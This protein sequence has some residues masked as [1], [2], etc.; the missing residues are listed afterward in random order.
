MKLLQI[1]R[2]EPDPDVVKLA[3]ILSDGNESMRFDLFGQEV[4][5]DRLVELVFYCDKTVSWW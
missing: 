4:D 3:N 2:S 1:F 5:Y